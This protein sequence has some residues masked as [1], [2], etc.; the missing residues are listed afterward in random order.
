MQRLQVGLARAWGRQA[1]TRASS[2]GSRAPQRH[3]PPHEPCCSQRQQQ[4]QRQ[5]Y[6]LIGGLCVEGSLRHWTALLSPS[7]SH[8]YSYHIPEQRGHAVGEEEQR[9]GHQAV[10]GQHEQ[11]AAG[12]KQCRG[13]QTSWQAAEASRIRS[14]HMSSAALHRQTGSMCSTCCAQKG[15]GPRRRTARRWRPCWSSR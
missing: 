12:R 6:Q 13:R 10:E 2:P 5:Q 1:L 14:W 3:R 11:E 9:R 4:Q 8:S 7:H 15:T